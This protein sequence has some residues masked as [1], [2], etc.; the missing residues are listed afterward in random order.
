MKLPVI[1]LASMLFCSSGAY[2]QNA[3]QEK[4]A[5]AYM[6]A[7]AHLDTQ[8][9]WDIQT[10]IKEYVWNTLSRNLFLLKK[11][12]D[13]VFN[14]E[15]GVKYAWMKEY[16][17]GEYE[18]LK[19]FITSG[20]WHISGS[21]WEASDVLVP[22]VESSIRNILLGQEYYR[23][24]F[25]VESTDIFLPDCFGFG[26]TLP[27]IASH[28]GLI[29]FSSQKL[30][31]R[32]N[33]F[34]GK[35]KHPFTIGLWQ[36]VDGS[37]IMLA[38][39]Y[40]YGKRWKDVDLSGDE[41][42][43][44]L[45][46]RTPLNTVYR[47]YGTGDTGGSPTLGS[48]NSVEKGIKGNGPLE[49]ISATSDQ[50]FKDYLPYDK[51]PELPVFNGELLMDVHGT[52]CY[53]SQA[54]MKLYNR[55]NELLGD[56][57]ER[58]AVAADWLGI[59]DYPGESL[60][61]SWKRFIFHQFHDDLTGTS[62]PR[63]YEFSWNDE[64]LSLKQ[65][66]GIL[67]TSVGAVS[68]KMDTRVKGTPVVFYNALGFPVT[69]VVEIAVEAPKFPKGV[70][71]YDAEGKKVASQFLSYEDGKVHLLV[72]ATVP[73]TGY[74]VYDI[75]LSGNQ[76]QAAASAATTAIEN[77]VYKISLNEQGD[78]TSLYDKTNNKELVKNGKSIRLALFTDNAS[79]NW[80]AWE[81]MKKT[82]D[83]TPVSITEDVRMT[84]S[85]DGDLRKTLCVE[86]RHGES[87]FR[88][89]IR[90]Y[91]GELAERIDFYNEIDWQST[92]A[93][94][95]AEFPLNLD[96]EKAT[97]DLGVGTVQRGN[98]VLTA[99]EVYAQYWADL[100]DR[101]GS[102]GV[103]IMNDSKYGWDKP[104]N[105]T[106]RLT[107]LHTPATKNNYSYQDRQDLGY[108]TFTYSLMPHA[109]NLDKAQIAK[110][111]EVL[112]QRVKAFEVEKHNGTLGKTFSLVSSDNSNVVIKAL[113]KAESSDEYVVRVYET[114]GKAPQ[115]AVLTFA[116]NILSANEADGTEK[117][118]GSAAF[119][120][121]QLQV[122]IQPN[123]IK[124]YKLRLNAAGKAALKFEQLPLNYDRKCFSWNEFR[125]EAD[126]ES[127]YSYSAELIP[128]E[129]AVNRVPFR[130][131][132]KEELNGMAC[133]GDTLQLP[134]GHTYNRLYIL[135]AAATAEQDSK[136]IF[137]A[138]KSV[139]EVV[140]PSYT[141]FI[142]Q[143]GH[144]GHTQGY[145][146]DVEVAYTGTHRHSAE[147]DQAYE[148]TYMFRFAIDIPAK[149][150]QI[151]LPDNKDIVLFA[152]TL[153]EEPYAPVKAVSTLFRT[154][155]KGNVGLQ[156]VTEPK[157]NLL[158]PEHIVAWSGYI[159]DK[160]KPAFLIDGNESTKW[161]D[162]SML[163][164]YVD[165]D[166]G[167]EKEISG[168]KVVNAAQENFSYITGGCF[169]QGRSSQDEAWRTLDFVTG[170][171]QNVINRSLGKAE[172]VRYLRLLVTQPVQAPN[173][174]ATRIYE[175]AVYK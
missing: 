123:S 152:A 6:V 32:V 23:Q 172:K 65:F 168:W 37:S 146:K 138:G 156:G 64:F 21:S 22:S 34:Y 84:L 77:S 89:Y 47:Y 33:P 166:L 139:Q 154:A 109:G 129:L 142:G 46:G 45:A 44:K 122:S 121:N 106:L 124:T 94:L 58:A 127:G 63:A 173:G 125:W 53:T 107:L 36:G 4:Q 141:G 134:A 130:L 10:T 128:A 8:W 85:E 24:E 157:V 19:S 99:Y 95:K 149:A 104:D 56:A 150:T 52:G 83:S 162:I 153:V 136:G 133:T 164:N 40:D 91:E 111:A 147:G 86:K 81:I 143:W 132:T 27:T 12:P 90:L 50:L 117:T 155:N 38:H 140:V 70:S 98:N 35:S 87:V 71:A 30:D 3:K 108:H 115:N 54:A 73:A 13:Y 5:K 18:Q 16:Y 119:N 48:V 144:T 135:A 113:K 170:N 11:Y 2:A 72:E 28:C 88:Q 102:Y 163:P 57:A 148:F 165:F 1:L 76:Q 175:F 14:F 96:N 80:P 167:A 112:N 39:G 78:I 100:T 42:L 74:A 137:R 171:K 51:H 160:E 55:Q 82:V 68:E 93:L 161:C 29:G 116:G 49:I 158:K 25:G 101:D 7:D 15:G 97:Y 92:N 61:E 67:T 75:R 17:P 60:T 120:G 26:W 131:E 151:I 145:L 114:G 174:K 118:T 31:W 110:D 69:D 126:F 59:A 105:H 62:I 79:Y 66:S 159:N 169:L 9:N 43:L 41:E 20:R 103:A